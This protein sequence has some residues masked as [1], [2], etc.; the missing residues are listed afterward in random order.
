[1]LDIAF[2]WYST[3]ASW[4]A[5]SEFTPPQD[6]PR[7]PPPPVSGSPG[8][9]MTAPM[10]DTSGRRFS[11]TYYNLS[12]AILRY[13]IISLKLLELYDKKTL[14]RSTARSGSADLY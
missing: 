1:M 11:K 14:T 6:P 3:K 9:D 12:K 8:L 5:T 2:S 13:I 10:R 7:D 4:G